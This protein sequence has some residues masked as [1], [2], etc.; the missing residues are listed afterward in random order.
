MKHLT[1]LLL[2]VACVLLLNN[3]YEIENNKVWINHAQHLLDTV[4]QMDSDEAWMMSNV[5]G[6]DTN[7][8]ELLVIKFTP[9]NSEMLKDLI[10]KKLIIAGAKSKN[11]KIYWK[12]DK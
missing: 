9:K 1:F 5:H 6:V 11:P 4:F 8:F 2:V 3:Y 7:G 12:E 10:G